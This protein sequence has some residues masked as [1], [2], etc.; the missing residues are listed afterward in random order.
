MASIEF[1][2][3]AALEDRIT[4]ERVVQL[5]DRDG[6]GLI[7]GGDETTMIEVFT[8]AN[9]VVTG[10][11]LGK[12]FT[13]AQLEL[14]KA[15]KQITRAW[16]GICA[17]LAGESKTEWLDDQGKGP[18]DGIGER[19]R[20][21]LKALSKGELRSR[22]EGEPDGTGR[23]PIIGGEIEA[24]SPTFIFN[25]NPGDRRGPGGF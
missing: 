3:R 18:Y 2:S 23:N 9:D 15:D 8:D 1:G 21:D 20:R 10:L 11:L 19:A 6:D 25:R 16:A 4:A 24:E 17:Q 5:F 14:L 7:T 22:I 12:G 13:L